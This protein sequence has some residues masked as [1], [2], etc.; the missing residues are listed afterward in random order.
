MKLSVQNLDFVTWALKKV[1]LFA[2]GVKQI[3]PGTILP[4]P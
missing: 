3:A 1:N 4:K 2:K